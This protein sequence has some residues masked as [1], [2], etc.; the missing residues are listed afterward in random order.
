MDEIIK[1]KS[2]FKISIAILLTFLIFS[3]FSAVS[4]EVLTDTDNNSSNDINLLNNVENSN[5]DTGLI[6]ITATS[7]DSEYL[8]GPGDPIPTI[9]VTPPSQDVFLN[10]AFHFNITF[11][12]PGPVNGYGPMVQ[13]IVPKGIDINSVSYLSMV[14]DLNKIGTFS[15]TNNYELFDKF[16]NTTVTLDESYEGYDLYVVEYPLGSFPPGVQ[17]A[18]LWVNA[19]LSSDVILGMPLN[20]TTIPWFSLGKSDQLGSEDDPIC[21][22]DVYSTVNPTAIKVSK[23]NSLHEGETATGSNYPFTY[24]INVEVAKDAILPNITICDVLPDSL[25]YI[26]G[27]LSITTPSGLVEG[28]N[29]EIILPKDGVNGGDIIIKFLKPITGNGSNTIEISYNVY[30]PEFFTDDNRLNTT[31]IIDHD[32]GGRTATNTV[33]VNG[34]FIH[35]VG[36]EEF[37]YTVSASNTNSVRLLPLAVQK[38]TNTSTYVAPGN[39][40]NYTINFQV[41]DYFALDNF[42]LTDTL[43]NNKILGQDQ[44]LD[45]TTNVTFTYKGLSF[46]F[47]LLDEKYVKL[48]TEENVTII[49]FN[50]SS[51]IKELAIL[52]DLDFSNLT[53]GF[54][55]NLSSDTS[56]VIIGG[57]TTGSLSY[58]VTVNR[59]KET[60]DTSTADYV[61][62][63][64]VTGTADNLNSNTG[65]TV[66]D[67]SSV[68]LSFPRL[69]LDK[70]L[71]AIN[72]ERITDPSDNSVSPGDNVTFIFTFDV[73]GGTAEFI[74]LTD[75]LPS[76]LFTQE[77][78]MAL[79][80]SLNQATGLIPLSGGWAYLTNGRLFNSEGQVV[81]PVI[82]VNGE[83]FSIYYDNTLDD[84]FVLRTI[85]ILFTLTISDY[86]M[87][88]GLTL[89][90]RAFLYWSYIQNTALETENIAMVVINQP[91]LII[92]KEVDKLIVEAGTEATYGLTVTNTGNGIAYNVTI[93]D[94][95]FEKY[96]D[97]G[98]VSNVFIRWANGTEEELL[99]NMIADLFNTSKG[100]DA[101]ILYGLKKNNQSSV[102]YPRSF[103]LFY[104]IIF[105]KNPQPNEIINN[106]ANITQFYA[107][108]GSNNNFVT[109]ETDD[110]DE[111]YADRYFASQTVRA[112]NL[113]FDKSYWKS[114]D[115][116][117]SNITVGETGIF[118]LTVTLPRLNV[119]NLTITDTL[120]NG[121]EYL[122]FD[123]VSG[124]LNFDKSMVSVSRNNNQI[125]FLF[126]EDISAISDEDR[127]FTLLLYFK[128]LDN[129]TYVPKQNLVVLTNNGI[130][131]WENFDKTNVQ[132]RIQKSAT[133][134]IYQPNLTINKSFTPDNVHSHDTTTITITVKNVGTYAAYNVTIWDDLS[135]LINDGFIILS[136]N[137]DGGHEDLIDGILRV[138]YDSLAVGETITL[139]LVM[140]NYD[141]FIGNKYNNT[142][143]MNYSSRPLDEINTEIRNYEG[144]AS[145]MVYLTTD[146]GTITKEI[147]N[148]SYHN[149]S[150]NVSLGET[151]TYVITV[152][153]PR[154]LYLDFNIMDYLPE[155]FE[156][157][158]FNVNWGSLVF[159]GIIPE[160]ILSPDGRTIS[161][162]FNGILNAT[163]EFGKNIFYIYINAT[164]LND[165]SN[166]NGVVKQNLVNMTWE[167][168]TINY[169]SSVNV[170]IVEPTLNINKFFDVPIIDGG[171]TTDL[172]IEVENVGS[173][174]AFNVTIVDILKLNNY[175]LFDFTNFQVSD[176]R[177][178]DSNDVDVTDNWMIIWDSDTSTF[179]ISGNNL[180]VSEYIKIFVPLVVSME[181]IVGLNYNNTVFANY[182]SWVDGDYR[183]Y[184]V[185][186]STILQTLFPDFYKTLVNATINLDGN[187]TI[188]EVA[189]YNITVVFEPGE[190]FDLYIVDILPLGFEFNE[191]E[192]DYIVSEGLKF[193]HSAVE[194]SAEN[195]IIT[196]IING[197][198][199]DTELDLFLTLIFNVT[200]K[201]D[202]VNN[203]T[204]PEKINIAY[205]N[206]NHEEYDTIWATHVSRIV[207]PLIEIN[208]T[209]NQTEADITDTV[210]YN[211]TVKNIGSSTAFNI[212]LTDV[213][214]ERFIY[215]FQN[216]TSSTDGWTVYYN[217][218]TRTFTIFGNNLTVGSEF[219]FL[220]NLTLNQ[221][222]EDMLEILGKNIT[223]IANIQY[224]SA[225]HPENRTYVSS[226]SATL[227]INACDLNVTIANF[228]EIVAGQNITYI[229]NVTNIGPDMAFDV[230]LYDTIPLVL[231]DGT[232]VR[233]SDIH[234]YRVGKDVNWVKW[235]ESEDFI[236]INL[237]NIASGES[238]I[239]YINGTLDSAALDNIYNNVSVS[240]ITIELDY[241]N[242]EDNV[243]NEIITRA[244]LYIN[245]SS[246]LTTQNVT[247]GEDFQYVITVTNNG[248]SVARNVNVYDELP[249]VLYNIFYSLNGVDWVD[250]DGSYNIGDLTPGDSRIIYIKASLPKNARGILNNTANL[251]TET[252]NTGINESNIIINIHVDENLTVNKTAN[253]THVNPGDYINYTIIIQNNGIS[254]T[255]DLIIYDLLDPNYFVDGTAYFVC[256]VDGDYENPIE[257]KWDGTLDI[258]HKDSGC[259]ILLY[260]WVQVSLNL[261]SN[262]IN[263][264][265]VTTD[266]VNGLTNTSEVLLRTADLQVNKTVSISSPEFGDE[267]VYTIT[268]R[269]N[270]PYNATNVT[271]VDKLPDGLNF[272]SSSDMVNY[273][274][275]TGIWNIGN[276]TVNQEVTLYITCIVD[277]TGDIE[278][279]VNVTCNQYDDN[280]DNNNYTLLIHVPLCDLGVSIINVTSVTAGENVT[281]LID[282]TNFGSDEARNVILAITL[283]ED[284]S[285]ISFKIGDMDWT[286]WTGVN[287]FILDIGDYIGDIN[288]GTS[289]SVWI[290]GILSAATLDSIYNNVSV[291]TSTLEENYENNNDSITNDILT[292]TNL[293]IAKSSN[294]TFDNITAGEKI[295]YIIT[296]TNNGP[297][298]AR[299]VVVY[300]ELPAILYD[301]YYSVNGVYMGLW[302]G[303]YTIGDLTPGDMIIIRINATLNESARNTLNNTANVTTPTN[304]TGINESNLT[305]EI[306]VDED[307]S[308]SKIANVSSVN[309]GDYIT[310]TITVKNNGISASNDLVIYDFLDYTYFVDGT[311]NYEWYLNNLLQG[312]GYWDGALFVGNISS[313]STV[314]LNI[315]LQVSYEINSNITN[316]ANVTTDALID[317]LT[318]YVEVL[319]ISV[320]LQVN[321]TVSIPRPEYGEE[322]VYTITV[323]NN[324][325][326]NATNVIVVDKLPIGLIF[327][328]SSDNDNYDNDTGI[329]NIGNLNNGQTVVLNITCIVTA[330]G[331]IENKVNVTC[332]QY[333]YNLN[334]NNYS[335]SIPV[336]LCDINV[337]IEKLTTLIAGGNITYLVNITNKEHD[338]K[339]I[340]YDPA[341]NVVLRYTIPAELSNI[342]YSFN[343]IDWFEWD[344]NGV[345]IGEIDYGN[346]VL[347]WIKGTVSSFALEV[348]SNV[349]VSTTTLEDDY[350]N[351]NADITNEVD[352]IIE[353]D[354]AKT[355]N[356]TKDGTGEYIFAG[357]SIQYNITVTNNGISSARNIIVNDI[358]NSNYFLDGATFVAYIDDGEIASGLWDGSFNIYILHPNQVLTIYINV[359]TNENAR[360]YLNNTANIT[361]SDENMGNNESN[362]ITTLLVDEKLTVSKIANVSSVNPG[363]YITYN[364]TVKNDGTS[365]ANDLI[366]KDD[367]NL[368][369]YQTGSVSYIWY[370]DGVEKGRGNSWDGTLLVGNISH[371]STVTLLLTLQVS[372][373]INLNIT[374]LV[375][376]TTHDDSDGISNESFIKLNVV[377]LQVN[378]TVSNSSP[379]YQNLI[380]YTITVRNNGFDNATG[381]VVYE[382]LQEGLILVSY[383]VSNGTFNNS[384]GLWTIDNLNVG[385]EIS[386]NITVLVNKTGTIVNNVVV[387]CEQYDED[388]DNNN[389]TV[390]IDVPL[391]ADL[392]ISITNTTEFIAGEDVI[393]Q[394]NI[395]NNGPDT[396]E[397]VIMVDTLPDELSNIQYSLDGGES[398]NLW[399]GTANFGDINSGSSFIIL[400][401]GNLNSSALDDNISNNVSVSSSTVDIDLSNNYAEIT[402]DIF[403]IAEVTIIKTSN[404]TEGY[405]IAGEEIQYNIT[406]T[407]NGPSVARDVFVYDILDYNYFVDGTAV[408]VWYLDGIEQSSKSWDGSFNINTLNP[409]QVLIIYINVTVRENARGTINNTATIDTTTNNT[410]TNHSSATVNVISFENIT[411]TKEAN[412]A[413]VNPGDYITYTI[414]VKNN[415]ISGSNDLEIT[416]I[417]DTNY[418]I[419]DSAYYIWYLDNVEKANGTWNGTLFVGN[420]SA[421]SEI[422]LNITVQVSFN[423]STN[424]TNTANITTFDDS[425]GIINNTTTKLNVLDL[426]VNKTVSNSN[427][428]YQDIINYT[429]TVKNNG[430]DNGTDVKVAITLPEG[431]IF[432]SYSTING[433]Y[434]NLTGLWTLD[435]LGVGEEFDLLITCM[436]NKT[437]VIVSYVNVTSNEYD[438]D[439]SNNY[440]NVNITVA[441]VVNLTVSE[442]LNQTSF[443]IGDN[444]TYAITISNGGPDDATGVYLNHLVSN[445]LKFVGYSSTKGSFD[446][447]T[448]KWDIGDL[449]NGEEL[450]IYLTYRIT[451]PGNFTSS[452]VLVSNEQE[453]D[454]QYNNEN[455]DLIIN[456]LP[457]D[458]STNRLPNIEK[459]I[460]KNRNN[461]TKSNE[462]SVSSYASMKPTG[463]SIIAGIL[464]IIVILFSLLG[465][466]VVIFKRKE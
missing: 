189:T 460:N 348:Y 395:T 298:V 120:P 238:I 297:S 224:S 190:Y 264:V 321:K 175:N 222:Y 105:N 429:I 178:Y 372:E 36:E 377:D 368:A 229:I 187:L 379:N 268:V 27:S 345:A 449:A 456:A 231:A 329:W 434:D 313:G 141:L 89:T 112:N 381:V 216:S 31:P 30:A 9:V 232:P 246:N 82:T 23:T 42:I 182:N 61:L 439:L 146:G 387:I 359:T 210:Q 147:F 66:S 428:N 111:S 277:T 266:H 398:W 172:I 18:V 406:V 57:A 11:T 423:V 340:P 346:S 204:N 338:I 183:G 207:E 83:T 278:N 194:F 38:Y 26:L 383:S 416:D 257:G 294:L 306:I 244:N 149:N 240:T 462:S 265:N 209:V 375:N 14:L 85:T 424:I 37:E 320:D 328:S 177:I 242:N 136:I 77:S 92:S 256:Y 448:G 385:E 193:D 454:L 415:G 317:G 234:F 281:Y 73:Y 70:G 241:D 235:D 140:V 45:L 260:I 402:N 116:D 71:Y 226:D 230:W 409:N 223:N 186:N 302:N 295:Q 10:S 157:S 293:N 19:Y 444:I 227:H 248:P 180:T 459:D 330:T 41:S 399:V 261:S 233:L 78:L 351:N 199:D 72:G 40:I 93:T 336:P 117:S 46:T 4:A 98:V 325:P 285:D 107:V 33:V 212:T 435:F 104:T 353:I 3:L 87:K 407:N 332:D 102:L 34:T 185:N 49:E 67:G 390:S 75:V 270:G 389:Y 144:I 110:D 15:L 401:K 301:A 16:S 324:G 106:T 156:F 171:F 97:Y 289:I 215:S 13:L 76:H 380:N 440:D 254:S 130:L 458:N 443:K 20:I 303:Y 376:V 54:Y 446:S 96:P 451:K 463:I 271:V 311:A 431:L 352:Y 55:H 432:M 427:P 161:I 362:L 148:T 296:V 135:Q 124:N 347:V 62:L 221:T 143:Y 370:I 404:I 421:G 326:D 279:N 181:V 237:G 335:I 142:A 24:H 169:S 44:E 192:W 200:V 50:I 58:L 139:T 323:K 322:I 197:E 284:L 308:I 219:T 450:V 94:D 419:S 195:G 211:I 410:E 396:A 438:F 262:V 393:Y 7:E 103:T 391:T 457:S 360:D 165:T 25:R 371:N 309:P 39:I 414:T 213:L 201:N 466:K 315:T 333:D 127:T 367:L 122:D 218:T 63:N 68:V 239:I 170:N 52:N 166:S 84:E 95:F 400:I 228:T 134:S 60:N 188:G 80:S 349:S 5:D 251:T 150:G 217:T 357:E 272:S 305:I 342:Y 137:T 411:V 162:L 283:S 350:T 436:V 21:G 12:N 206:W 125:T 319:L 114:N 236:S 441:P 287:D 413:N 363:E 249:S 160:Q 138:K 90:N 461:D 384:T 447:K 179:T 164:V 109:A 418:F 403:T 356:A 361:T 220:F 167:N 184:A 128:V 364:I 437:G 307:I 465:N 6:G 337:T 35:Q 310:Y 81:V 269:N 69:T 86:K 47:S 43:G 267:I 282:I 159:T 91:D 388:L 225:D 344:D 158:G 318:D 2:I 452:I 203:L 275:D 59:R 74:N 131:T 8:F 168:N 341:Y 405:I 358:L 208:K 412:V 32:G 51:I 243:T 100:F 288:S 163:D 286:Q 417:L 250:W 64:T 274:N 343:E 386:L 1:S 378:K 374:N 22:Y 420:I 17:A 79:A 56:E 48:T 247:A 108:A 263:M 314:V 445:G 53:G 153:L 334:N 202:P 258:G 392:S 29:Y 365:G 300:D 430:P 292:W 118:N 252:N 382:I 115:T 176:I 88:D 101:G 312:N 299:E 152:D 253:V 113:T 425:D 331:N 145:D 442:S 119:A 422:I 304:N 154:G 273:D 151:I 123:L 133:V 327:I 132:A 366:I 373:D 355:S 28:E 259:T 196:F 453:I 276:L 205:L 455:N 280:L 191:G 290:N 291:S 316:I 65:S 339:G 245:K 408:Y 155:G 126:L 173:S 397:S 198:I 354:I 255:N 464:Y 99:P 121:L 174:T 426:Q 214:D 394:I 433:S 369:Y 129:L